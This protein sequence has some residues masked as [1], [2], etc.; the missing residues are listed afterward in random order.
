MKNVAEWSTEFDLYYQNIT[1]NQAPGLTEYEKSVYLTR[2]A[3][4]VQINLY[5]GNLGD[6]FEETE[7]LAH[8]LSASTGQAELSESQC[9]GQHLLYGS[10][11]FELPEDLLFRTLELCRI[12]IPGCGEQEVIVVPVTQDEFWRTN[13]NPFKGPNESKVLRLSFGESDAF[14]GKAYTQQYS[15][16]ISKYPVKSYIVRYIKRPDPIILVDLSAE[17]KSINGQTAVSTCTM[18]EALHQAILMGA[19]RAAKAA[20]TL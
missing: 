3:E 19:V 18:P 11:M 12:E 15:E 9:S 10:V 2:E 1:S 4:D 17:G 6:A 16:I 7:E 20:W 13:R 5:K 14:G 8:Y